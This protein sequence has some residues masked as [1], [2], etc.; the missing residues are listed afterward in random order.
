M[1]RW[2]CFFEFSQKIV[3]FLLMITIFLRKRV[4]VCALA[5][6]DGI[7]VLISSVFVV[8]VFCACLYVFAFL[9][10]KRVAFCW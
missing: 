6:K 3:A 10:N 1:L 7:F 9:L 2:Y 4:K 8:V 5:Q